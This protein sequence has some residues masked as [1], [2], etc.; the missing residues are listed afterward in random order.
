MDRKVLARLALAAAAVGATSYVATWDQPLPSALTV[1]WKGTGVGFLAVYAAIRARSL[2]GWLLAALMALGAAGDV[3]LDA[4]GQTVGGA[5]FFA[6]HL[7]AMALYLR[8]LRPGLSGAAWFHAAW[9]PPIAAGAAFILPPDQTAAPGIALYALGG[10]GAAALAWLSRFPRRVAVGATIFLISDEL[11]FARMGPL[12]GQAWVDY[13]VWGL[14][15]AGQA[16]IATG[17]AGA[18]APEP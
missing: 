12:H 4:A 9:L 5:A 10:A 11:I 18:L 8:N 14:Y 2:D 7:L 6:G 1:A 17:A 16:L 3:L 15:F 13:A